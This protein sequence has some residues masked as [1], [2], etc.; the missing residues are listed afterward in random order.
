MGPSK[1]DPIVGIFDPIVRCN[2]GGFLSK[3]ICVW[4]DTKGFVGIITNFREKA[5]AVTTGI[6]QT[7]EDA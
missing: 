7:K 4:S 3:E 2:G 6:N 5:I 1:L